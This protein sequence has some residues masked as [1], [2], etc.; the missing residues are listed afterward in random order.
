MYEDKS[1]DDNGGDNLIVKITKIAP[2]TAKV[3]NDS[4]IVTTPVKMWIKYR[5]KADFTSWL[6]TNAMNFEKYVEDNFYMNIQYGTKL[7]IEPNWNIYTVSNGSF[8]WRVKPDFGVNNSFIPIESILSK[9][10]DMA[11]RDY[12]KISDEEFKR[13]Y[14]V[15]DLVTDAWYKIQKP[16][17]VNDAYKTYLTFLPKN[18]AYS[19]ISS[20]NDAINFKFRFLS[21]IET[22][23]GDF[24]YRPLDNVKLP[25][26]ELIKDTKEGFDVSVKSFINYKDVSALLKT[27]LTNFEFSSEDKKTTGKLN[28]IDVFG[29]RDKIYLKINVEGKAKKWIFKKKFKGDLYL[30]G[31]PEFNRES[32]KIRIS[33]FDFSLD[34]KDVLAKAAGKLFANKLKNMVEKK[35]EFDLN[36]QLKTM[37][38]EVN[39]MISTFDN[40]YLKLD[41]KMETIELKELYLVDNGIKIIANFKGGI[42]AVFR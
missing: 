27:Q 32:N 41:A 5:I 16:F 38:I 6:P 31:K 24:I 18:V 7:Q 13:D 37:N 35:L 29:D 25:K 42:K 11:L 17:V 26:L 3:I 22:Q 9:V 33:G 36:P 15:K 20:A 34:S 2:I 14:P 8:T 4:L 40:E 28:D 30:G 19:P 10:V 39:K 1:F 21:Q 23:S 12:A